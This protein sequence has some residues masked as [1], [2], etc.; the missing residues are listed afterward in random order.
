MVKEA[1]GKRLAVPPSR[2]RLTLTDSW[3]EPLNYPVGESEDVSLIKLLRVCFL[4]AL[5]IFP[6][7]F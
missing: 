3:N 2:I 6:P 7:P 4:S 5:S 1:L